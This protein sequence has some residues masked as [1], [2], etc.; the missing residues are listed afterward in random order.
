MVMKSDV[1]V[2]GWTT[3]LK[4]MLLKFGSFPQQ[5]GVKIPKIF[6]VSPSS[7]QKSENTVKRLPRLGFLKYPPRTF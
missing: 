5:I 2:G 3:H 7:K 4:N 1:L 6:E